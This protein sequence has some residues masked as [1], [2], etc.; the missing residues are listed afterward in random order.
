MERFP[1]DHAAHF[2]DEAVPLRIGLVSGHENEPPAKARFDALDR[3]VKLVPGKSGHH[4]VTQD[5]IEIRRHD[6]AQS[7]H[8]IFGGCD[9]AG[10]GREK[11]SQDGRQMWVI[12]HQEDHPPTLAI[13]RTPTSRFH[14]SYYLPVRAAPAATFKLIAPFA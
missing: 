5:D 14:T 12:I 4:H 7:F 11:L 10:I 13:I 3:N 2:A 9:V 8:A 6:V 1:Q